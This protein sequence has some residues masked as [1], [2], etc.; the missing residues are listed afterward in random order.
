MADEQ[1]KNGGFENFGRKVDQKMKDTMPKIEAE[2]QRII[3]Y[4]NNEVVPEVRREGSN[5][6]RV[7]A[8]QLRKLADYMEAK[9]SGE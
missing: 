8:E 9:K 3:A 2:V 6:L 1:N 7:A 4:M 5:A